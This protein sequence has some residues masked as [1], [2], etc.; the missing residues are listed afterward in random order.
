MNK[1]VTI[2]IVLY[3]IA[4]L[5]CLIANLVVGLDIQ[6]NSKRAADASVIAAQQA[7]ELNNGLTQ[8]KDNLV[9][10]YEWI[11]SHLIPSESSV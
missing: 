1:F 6:Q 9:K 10:L 8:V 2:I 5:G 11:I 3:A 7:V 4:L